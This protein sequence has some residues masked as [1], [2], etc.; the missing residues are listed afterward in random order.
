MI[1]Y[2]IYDL[3]KHQKKKRNQLVIKK[4]V[5]ISGHVSAPQEGENIK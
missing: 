1:K 2:F 3:T 5:R 4:R